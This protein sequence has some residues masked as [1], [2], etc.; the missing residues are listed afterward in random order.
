[1]TGNITHEIVVAYSQC[2]LKAFLLLRSEDHGKP[3]EYERL[4][5]EHTQRNRTRYR[6]ILKE[7]HVDTHLDNDPVLMIGKDALIDTPLKFRDLETDSCVLSNKKQGS[8][9]SNSNGYSAF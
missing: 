1:M 5:D 7:K 2:P 6:N 4:I 9:Y 3:H 8:S